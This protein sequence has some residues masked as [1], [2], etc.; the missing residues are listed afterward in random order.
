MR[1][2]EWSNYAQFSSMNPESVFQYH[3][4]IGKKC[5]TFRTASPRLLAASALLARSQ[6]FRSFSPDAKQNILYSRLLQHYLFN[7]IFIVLSVE[8]CLHEK[9]F[10]CEQWGGRNENKCATSAS[11]NNL[12]FDRMPSRGP[13][14]RVAKQA[15]T[16]YYRDIGIYGGGRRSKIDCVK[17]KIGFLF[18]FDFNSFSKVLVLA[19]SQRSPRLSHCQHHYR[20]EMSIL[21]PFTVHFLWANNW[22]NYK[23]ILPPIV[24]Q[25]ILVHAKQFS[26]SLSS[27]PAL[28]CSYYAF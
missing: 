3:L 13:E 25:R 10:G 16:N 11:R 4:R 14:G 12:F 5:R 28:N 1:T 17:S 24:A 7:K 9:L 8:K 15:K 20:A 23:G 18:Q 2:L 19:S 6:I 27:L 21:S 26:K 22:C